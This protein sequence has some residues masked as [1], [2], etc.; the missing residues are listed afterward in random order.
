MKLDASTVAPPL[1]AAIILALIITQTREALTLSG[2][3]RRASA[4]AA[5]APSPFASLERL[6]AAPP[7]ARAELPR[8]PLRSGAVPQVAVSRPTRPTPPPV[9]AAPAKP[10]LTS[11]VFDADPRATVRWNGRDYSVRAGTLFADFRVTSVDRDQVVLDRGGEPVV[12]R[13]PKR[14]DT[15]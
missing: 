8:D 9:P 6:L 13:L 10:V 15:E 1:A 3:W 4:A 2:A 5:S 11:I 7:R 12:L 14:G